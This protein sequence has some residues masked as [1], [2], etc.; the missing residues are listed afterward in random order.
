MVK[1]VIITIWF[2]GSLGAIATSLLA[3]SLVKPLVDKYPFLVKLEEIQLYLIISVGLCALFSIGAN[4]LKDIIAAKPLLEDSQGPHGEVILKATSAQFKK[5]LDEAASELANEAEIYFNAAERD[6]K[7]RRYSDAA[8]NYQ[9]SIDAIPTMSAYLN[10]GIL[11]FHIS[12]L[13]Q[14]LDA[15]LSGIRIARSKGAREMEAVFLDILAIIYA[16]KGEPDNAL[17]LL[18]EA[19]KINKQTGNQLAQAR[20]LGN[21]GVV[22]K[23]IGNLKEAL[24]S[25]EEAYKIFKQVRDLSNQ[26]VSLSN[27]GIIYSQQGKHKEALKFHFEALEINKRLNNPLS[28]ARDLGNIGVEYRIQG[29][30]DE[31][32]KYYNA[33]LKIEEQYGHQLGQANQ[34]ANI[35]IVYSEQGENSE[36]LK[37]LESARVIY[38]RIGAKTEGFLI[39]EKKIKQLAAET[40]KGSI[41]RE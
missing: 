13:P 23:I 14:A 18:N 8:V 4:A 20:D 36:A 1:F 40:D 3:A 31:A 24:N 17:K 37:I 33:A 9:R 12:D 32:L 11:L 6:F 27:I 38:L 5:E 28:S 22:Y 29:K 41:P 16:N 26:A 2:F 34:L 19:L 7:A 10:F 25:Y 15:C 21:I 35:G 39:V 30:L